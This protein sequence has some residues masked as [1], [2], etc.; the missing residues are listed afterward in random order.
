MIYD[1]YYNSLS[2]GCRVLF[3]LTSGMSRESIWIIIIGF[4]ST[5]S[6]L[7]AGKKTTPCHFLCDWFLLPKRRNS[8]LWHVTDPE[9]TIASAATAQSYPHLNAWNLS[10]GIFFHRNV[11]FGLSYISLCFNA[12]KTQQ[13]SGVLVC[14]YLFL[15]FFYLKCWQ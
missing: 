3:V 8:N 1:V 5:S 10:S 9:L 11:W 2:A 6:L 13:S 12:T 15:L 14:T 7:E 4:F